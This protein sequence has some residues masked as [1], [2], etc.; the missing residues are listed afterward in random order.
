MP[1]DR[2]NAMDQAD[3]TVV[4]ATIGRLAKADTNASVKS[5]ATA[6]L[7]ALGCDHWVFACENPTSIFGMSHLSAGIPFQWVA[8]YLAKG[9]LHIDPIVKHFRMSEELLI[10]DAVDGWDSAADGVR[11]FMRGLH[12]S[13]FGSGMAIPLRSPNGTKGVLSLV[14][15][16]PLV[17]T[18][19]NY[20][21][22]AETSRAIGMAIY[23]A[24]ERITFL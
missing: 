5:L 7:S 22:H 3:I 24:I 20:L 2:I 11:D 16:R 10:W 19:T 13:G 8:T 15:P 18:R 21:R 23:S 12:A 9:Y 6:G 4:E 17:E 14:S 1:P